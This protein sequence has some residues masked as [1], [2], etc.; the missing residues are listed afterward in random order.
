MKTAP[1]LIGALII[2]LFAIPD[3]FAD[4]YQQ[5]YMRRDGTYVQPHYQSSPDNSY[6]NNW[7]IRG[8]SNPYTGKSGTDSPTWND[9]SPSSNQNLY[10]N[11][12][13]S[14]QD[15]QRRSRSPW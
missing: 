15:T 8:N 9:R 6:N 12:G 11:P 7:G 2:A 5:G 1:K 14:D 10:G 3:T 13:Y 4:Q